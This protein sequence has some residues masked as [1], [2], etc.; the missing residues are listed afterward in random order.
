MATAASP[1]LPPTPRSGS[2]RCS[3]TRGPSRPLRRSVSTSASASGAT[4]GDGVA[5][6]AGEVNS[7]RSSVTP[8]TPPSSAAA[9]AR[10]TPTR[11]SARWDG[12]RRRC[13]GG[14]LRRCRRRRPAG[15]SRRPR[16]LRPH[17]PRQRRALV[18]RSRSSPA[19]R[20]A[21]APAPALTDFVVMTKDSTVL[22]APKVVAE[23]MG[24]EISMEELGGPRSTA[25][26]ASPT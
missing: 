20:P 7:R 21:A 14:R 25:R 18:R 11:S 5:A 12:R 9:S 24:E 13:P 15:G 10:S 23:A 3:A 22:T 16:R 19:S 1:P 4:P 6:G 26:T 8:R 17:L 2:C